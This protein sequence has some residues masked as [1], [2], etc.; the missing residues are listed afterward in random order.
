MKFAQYASRG[1]PAAEFRQTDGHSKLLAAIMQLLKGNEP[2]MRH[3]TAS[4]PTNTGW[5]IMKKTSV[6]WLAT[7]HKHR[8]G[9]NE[10][11]PKVLVGPTPQ[12]Q[13]VQ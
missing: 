11:G 6:S 12:T 8:T 5:T 2:K 10:L 13:G 7:P 4:N 9:S 1:S 3:S